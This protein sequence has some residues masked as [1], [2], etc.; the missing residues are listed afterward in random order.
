MNTKIMEALEAAEE[1]FDQRADAEYFT[2]SP[3]PVPNEEMRIL[4]T[5]RKA[6]ASTTPLVK[7]LQ[8]E[9]GSEPLHPEFWTAE[10]L[11]GELYALSDY[12]AP[13]VYRYGTDEING[14]GSDETF[15]TL[16][17]AKAAAQADYESRILSAL[18]DR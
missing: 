12:D 17:E 3:R 10:S 6:L 18:K 7:P 1:Y 14:F 5:I 13:K 2:D 11:F 8:W 16:E 9:E 4:T 15:Q